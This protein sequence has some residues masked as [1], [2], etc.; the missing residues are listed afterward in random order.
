MLTEPHPC[1]GAHSGAA[2]GNGRSFGSREKF[3]KLMEDV[4]QAMLTARLR[5]RRFFRMLE[6]WK[7]LSQPSR[8]RS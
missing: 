4:Y 7:Y 6:T 8:K 3:R 1:P 5:A 2:S